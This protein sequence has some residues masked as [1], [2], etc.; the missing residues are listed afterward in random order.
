MW[1]LMCRANRIARHFRVKCFVW[2]V[3]LLSAFGRFGI[4]SSRRGMEG[5]KI[6]IIRV[7]RKE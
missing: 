4:R 7:I 1:E 5:A 3:R 2:R 6:R